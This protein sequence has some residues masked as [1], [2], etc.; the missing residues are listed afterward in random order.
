MKKYFIIVI[1]ILFIFLIGAY[2]K[3]LTKQ[4]NYQ[5]EVVAST[6]TIL[7]LENIDKTKIK[8]VT[9]DT[10]KIRVDIQG[11]EEDMTGITMESD[12]IF[13]KF[14]FSEDWSNIS[15][16]ITVPVGMLIDITLSE[17]QDVTIMDASGEVIVSGENSFLIDSSTL[18][19]F[20]VGSGGAIQLDSWGNLIV[21]DDENWQI[22]SG[23]QEGDAS[24]SEG[25]T[26]DGI[27]YCGVGS[28]AI[29]DYCCVTQNQDTSVPECDGVGYFYFD[30]VQ[31]G[32][33]FFCEE[34]NQVNDE[35]CSIGGQTERD[36][37]CEE[38]HSGEYAGCIGT[39]YFNNAARDCNI[40]CNGG[41]G[42]DDGGAVVGGGGDSGGGDEG[43]PSSM[44]DDSISNFCYTINSQEGKDE[45]CNDALKNPLSTGPRSG[46]PDCIGTWD[47][48]IH[49]GCTFICADREEMNQI[50]KEILQGIQ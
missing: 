32:C 26:E 33:E 31:R 20:T 2:A 4:V 6:S 24:Q 47:F 39:W 15:G 23:D 19:S 25:D 3:L 14:G 28:Q 35:D 7:R 48:D 44:Y 5:R 13:A 1:A 41:A 8:I 45:C 42:D 22:L 29:R 38:L 17:G 37:C 36:A 12:S 34:I 49:E 50:L 16:T 43:E 9:A 11:T 18:E 30:N 27:M 10:D 46:F 40:L 21:W